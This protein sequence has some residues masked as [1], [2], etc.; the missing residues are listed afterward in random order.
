M[1]EL[2]GVL[3]WI[4]HACGFALAHHVTD[5][6]GI[7]VFTDDSGHICIRLPLHACPRRHEDGRMMVTEY[8]AKSWERLGSC[9][10][11][12]EEDTDHG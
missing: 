11:E 2:R 3:D 5:A 6:D 4:L 10:L 1:L 8:D 9:R 12:D 7:E